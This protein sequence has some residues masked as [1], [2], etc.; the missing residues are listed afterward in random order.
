M[1]TNE[2]IKSIESM[3][4]FNRTYKF[5]CDFIAGEVEAQGAHRFNSKLWHAL[6]RERESGKAEI[7]PR[8]FCAL[9]FLRA[10][11]LRAS[12]NKSRHERYDFIAELTFHNLKSCF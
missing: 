10:A 12:A 11:G 3:A 2:L 9:A 1:T 7:N 6:K 4:K 8:R 5:A